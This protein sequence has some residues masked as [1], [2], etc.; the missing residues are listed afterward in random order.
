MKCVRDL[1]AKTIKFL[2]ENKEYLFDTG[3]YQDFVN[4]TQKV[5][6]CNRKKIDEMYLIKIKNFDF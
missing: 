3:L 6:N 2:E 5:Q 4:R 1:R